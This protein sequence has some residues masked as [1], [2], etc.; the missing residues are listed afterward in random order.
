R[1]PGR[2]APQTTS[3]A[4]VEYVDVL[5]TF[6]EAAGGTIPK[7][8]EG[9]SLLP[10]L[11]GEVDHHKKFVFGLMTTRGINAGAPYYGIRSIRSDQYRLIWNL[12]PE[13]EFRNVIHNKEFFLSWKAQAEKGEVEA[14]RWVKRYYESPEYELY[15]SEEDPLEV[16]NLIDDPSLSGKVEELKGKLETWMADQGDLGQETEMAAPSRMV[17]SLKTPKG[18]E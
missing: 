14:Q 13:A 9:K 2:V 4:M 6:I 17:R 7:A 1:W 15:H 3:E 8:L 10:L 5:P 16:N 18:K 11:A 12:T